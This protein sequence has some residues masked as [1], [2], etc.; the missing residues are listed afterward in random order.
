MSKSI[1]CKRSPRIINTDCVIAMALYSEDRA[2]WLRDAI[3]SILSQSFN[4]FVFIIVIDGPVSVD[5]K[6]ALF[7][8]VGDDERVGVFEFSE[9]RGLSAAMNYAI[10]WSEFLTPKF[11]FRMDAD[12]ISHQQRL[13]EQIDFLKKH[14]NVDVLGSSLYEID[15]LSRQVGKRVLPHKH[16][17]IK[18][19][20]FTRC[21]LNHPTVCIRY[22]VFKSGFRYDES[23][24]NTQDYF[25]WINLMQAGFKFA[26]LKEPLLHFRRVNNF[27][28]R[29]GFNK[30]LNEFRARRLA[31]KKLNKYRFRYAFY[32]VSVLIVRMMPPPIIRF[33]YAIDRLLLRH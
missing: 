8:E 19:M 29:R 28:K 16:E 30:S 21:P 6:N 12:D 31:M 23:L 7:T 22:N 24:K 10:E 33:A 1:E 32:A 9:N 26:N 13:Q 15:E 25:L 18:K 20:I 14:H 3:R 17:K 4:D 5:L 11:F 2:E 27:Y